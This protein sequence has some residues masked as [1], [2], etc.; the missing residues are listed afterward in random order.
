M[1]Q[2]MEKVQ[3]YTNLLHSSV[4]LQATPE[5]KT[6]VMSLR[7]ALIQANEGVIAGTA[8]RLPP[9]PLSHPRKELTFKPV[10][11]STVQLQGE[12]LQNPSTLPTRIGKRSKMPLK[13]AL[14]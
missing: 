5:K 10:A 12:H 7:E 1:S 2:G 6:K 14:A 11:T 9:R 3:D 13:G 4:P 8:N